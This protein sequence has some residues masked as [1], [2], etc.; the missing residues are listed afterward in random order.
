LLA[1]VTSLRFLPLFAWSSGGASV[2]IGSLLPEDMPFCHRMNSNRNQESVTGGAARRGS[3]GGRSVIIAGAW[4]FL[5]LLAQGFFRQ[6]TVF[7]LDLTPP[8]GYN[9]ICLSV[10]GAAPGNSRPLAGRYLAGRMTTLC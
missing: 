7:R 10:G 2:E 8:Y 3:A 9:R 1:I 4:A 6:K 5:A